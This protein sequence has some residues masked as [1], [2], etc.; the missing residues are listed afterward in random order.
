MSL[1]RQDPAS[2]ITTLPS[3]SVCYEVKFE[4]GSAQLLSLGSRS[5]LII[6]LDSRSLIVN[7]NCIVLLFEMFSFLTT[8]Q[9]QED[10][11]KRLVECGVWHFVVFVVSVGS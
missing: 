3:L 10:V 5:S 11:P 7:G 6:E 8:G 9:S 2:A 4:K 1:V